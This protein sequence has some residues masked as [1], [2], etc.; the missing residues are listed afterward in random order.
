MNTAYL[1]SKQVL[2]AIVLLSG[3]ASASEVSIIVLDEN[4][5]PIED[6]VVYVTGRNLMADYD[7]KE[8]VVYQKD[9]KF[10]PYITVKTPKDTLVFENKDAISHHVFTVLSKELDFR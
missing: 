1:F 3:M 9:K 7:G 10:S 2:I 5:Q 6:V 8:V 4:N